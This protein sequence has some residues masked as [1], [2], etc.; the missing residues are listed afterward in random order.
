MIINFDDGTY[1]EVLADS[2][3]VFVDETGCEDLKDPNFPFF[4]LGGCCIKASDY[5]ESIDK[6][7]KSLKNRCFGAQDISLHA[8]GT[9]FSKIQIDGLNDYFQSNMFGRF[10][11]VASCGTVDTSSLDLV[12]T[13]CTTMYNRV[14][15]IV[16]EIDASEFVIIFE[17]S[18]RLRPKLEKYANRISIQKEVGNSCAHLKVQFLMASKQIRMSGLEVSDFIIHTAGTTCRDQMQGRINKFIERK[19]FNSIFVTADKKWSS[20]MCI[21]KIQHDLN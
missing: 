6:P 9:K 2:M 7:W 10:A 19:D 20:F 1:H 4:G 3:L 18:K 8:A 13:V 12:Y 15:D 11:A 17:E 16:K 21:K 5:Y 14:A